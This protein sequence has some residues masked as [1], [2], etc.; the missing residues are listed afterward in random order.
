MTATI[1]PASPADIAELRQLYYAVYGPHYP[2]ALGTD[3]DAMLRLIADPD[4]LW[5]VARCPD[6]GALTASAAIHGEP[7][8]RVGRL[9]GLA[10]HPGHRAGGLASA[11]TDELCRRTLGTGRLDSVYATVRTVSAGPQRVVA[12]NGFR[13]LGLLANAVDLSARESLALYARHSAG[14]LDRR[15]PVAEVP[16]PLA[17]LLR[18]AERSLGI[19][20]GRTRTTAPRPVP[21]RPA[22]PA[23]RLEMIEAPGF[24]RRRFRDRFPGAERW[25]Y[26][27]HLPNTL[28]V[29]DDDGFEVY[30]YLNRAGRYSSLVAAYPEPEAA[31]AW[32]EPITRALTR[33]G[34]GYVEALLPL[35]RHDL[36]STFLAQGF[37]PGALYPA[38]R[39]ETD[40]DGRHDYVVMSRTAEQIDFR[41]V[42]ADGPLQPY[43]DAYLSTWASTYLPPFEVAS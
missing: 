1:D 27:L 43:L 11:L 12:R 6:T 28:L 35:A 17:P 25:F 9:E 3:P 39:P 37:I 18:A 41:G 7:G 13:P 5:L 22:A 16:A 38:M 26:P 8:G 21:A 24:V 19:D 42:V 34:A 20:Y 33:A 14:V 4:T 31:A 30:A 23:D 36:L 2:S 40:G 15:I 32:L 29:P 10:V